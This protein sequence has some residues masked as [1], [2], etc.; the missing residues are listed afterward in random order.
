VRLEE[1]GDVKL[2]VFTSYGVHESYDFDIRCRRSG[3]YIF[4]PQE[5]LIRL[6]PHEKELAVCVRTEEY[7]QLD[8]KTCTYIH[9]SVF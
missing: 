4:F 9:T 3:L 1:K 6:F 8:A 5:G 2:G 7:N